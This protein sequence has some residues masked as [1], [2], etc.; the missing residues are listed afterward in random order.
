[1]NESAKG[2]LALHKAVGDVDLAA[3]VGQPG[4][5]FDGVDVVGDGDKLGLAVFDEFGDVVESELEVVGLGVVD[6]FF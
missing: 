3:E 2:A 4:D 1:M 5:K 6:F